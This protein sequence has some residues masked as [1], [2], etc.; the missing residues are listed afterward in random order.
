MTD[1]TSAPDPIEE[2]PQVASDPE[3]AAIADSLDEPEPDAEPEPVLDDAAPVEPEA[4]VAAAVHDAAADRVSWWPFLVYLALWFVFAGVTVWRF[5]NMSPGQAIY[6]SSDYALSVFAG[7]ALALA[8]PILVL[9][10]W[11]AAWGKPGSSKWGL[12]V[13][14]LL[15]G[16][17]VTLGG[18][19]LWWIALMVVD[20]LRLGRIL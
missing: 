10:T 12:L 6:D 4:V 14:A 13:D 2:Q 17:V 18:V 3:I 20:Q 9:A 8:G 11:V 16:S 5:Y 19:A 15:K 7:I 1:E